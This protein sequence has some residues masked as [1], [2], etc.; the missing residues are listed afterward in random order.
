MEPLVILLFTQQQQDTNLIRIKSNN[1]FNGSITNISVKEV[2]QNWDLQTGWSIAE[3]KATFDKTISGPGNIN[4][5]NILASG[6]KYKL[7]FDTLETNGGNIAYRFGGGYTFILAIQANTTHT[8]YGVGAGVQFT[9]RG[10][11]NF[12]G[13]IT[14]ISVI[15]ITDDTNL[16]RINYEGFSYQDAL[17]SELITN[18]GFN[19]GTNNWTQQLNVNFSVDNGVATIQSTGGNSLIYQYISPST[20]SALLKIEFDV[21]SFS[22][23]YFYI[24]LGGYSTQITQTGKVVIYTTSNRNSNKFDIAPQPT[25]TI[26]LNN[27]SVKEYLGQEVVPGSGCGSWLW[28]PQSTNLITQSELFSDSIWNKQNSSVVSGFASPSGDLNAFKLINN[29]TASVNKY[30]RTIPAAT[31][32]VDYSLSVF[33]KKGEYDKLRVEDGNN[34]QGA[35][36]DLSNGTFSA[37]GSSV[38]AKIE[39]YGNGWYRCSITK[40][41]ITTSIFFVIAGS[42]SQSL[43]VGD[44]T[45]GIYIWGAMLEQNSFSTSYI[46][47]S[48][49]QVT[50]NQ[51]VCTNGG[52]LASINSTEGTLYAE[53]AALADDLTLRSISLSDGTTNNV[54]TIRYRTN[55]NRIQVVVFS[56]GVLQFSNSFDV[57]NILDFNKV[58]IS[59]NQSDF[60]YW[61]NGVKRANSTSGNTPIG[62]NKLSFDNGGSHPFFGKTK[63]LAV[64]KEA[65]SDSE[66]QSLTTI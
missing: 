30:I 29:T 54:A 45:S 43:Q 11:D 9:L 27:V 38:V 4:Q 36:F 33:A 35:W 37:V 24:S 13:S 28:E 52:S 59:Y 17:G 42:N 62:M 34:S 65:L 32:G 6:K 40:P 47:T 60:N 64:W 53:I 8:V 16:P 57:T 58:A 14:N 39:D 19:D 31:S 23:S 20:N 51:D 1:S 56:G 5:N 55:S 49:S 2:G 7:T 48:G 18:G 44:G 15:E 50:R 66:L 41:S 25:T 26:K 10:S 3:N 61:V 22:G 46:P 21:V 12:I 63:A